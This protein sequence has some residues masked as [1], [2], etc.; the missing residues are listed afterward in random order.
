MV[1]TIIL[2]ILINGYF[3]T[4]FALFCMGFNCAEGSGSAKTGIDNIYLFLRMLCVNNST[5]YYKS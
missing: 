5:K 3:I 2:F 4:S 1:A